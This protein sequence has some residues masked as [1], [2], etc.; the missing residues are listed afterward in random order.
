MFN[1]C[2]VS[3]C[4]KM[5]FIILLFLHKFNTIIWT[6]IMIICLITEI[7]FFCFFNKSINS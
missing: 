3:V 5:C 2:L 6:T 7:F 4:P 1:T